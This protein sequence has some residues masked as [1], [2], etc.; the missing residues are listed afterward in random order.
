MNSSS[1]TLSDYQYTFDDDGNVLSKNDMVNSAL[2]QLFTYDNL[3]EVTSF[4]E[5]TISGG[6]IS[7]PST[8]QSWNLRCPGQLDLGHDERHDPDRSANA[9]NEYTSVSGATTPAYDANGNMT[10]DSAGRSTSIMPG[11]RSS[12]SRTRRARRWKLTN[13]MGLDRRIAV[14]DSPTSTTTNLYYSSASQVLEE[15]VGGDYTNAMSG[16]RS[17]SML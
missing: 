5:G 14:T 3:G 12:R 11:T 17:T 1:T 8:S 16:A 10:T 13:M 2:G 4:E 6:T 9:Q 7:S 15:S